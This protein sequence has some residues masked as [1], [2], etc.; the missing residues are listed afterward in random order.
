MKVHFQL[1]CKRVLSLLLMSVL[2]FSLSACTIEWLGEDGEVIIDSSDLMIGIAMPTKAI[3]RWE[4]DGAAINEGLLAAGYKTKL[5]YA[6][7]DPTLQ[8]SQIENMITA[9]CDVMIVV[10]VDSASLSTVLEKAKSKNI[11]ILSYDRLITDTSAVDFYVTFDNYKVGTSMGQFIIDR[12]DL[13]N[14]SGQYNMEIF[15]GP[16]ADN[17]AAF[18]YQ[19]AIDVLQPYINSGVI[20]IPSGQITKEQAAIEGWDLGTAQSRMENLLNAFY[21]DKHLDIALCSNDALARG[22]MNGLLSHGYTV[23][24]PDFPIVTG[25]DCEIA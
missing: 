17:N 8:V 11:R 4:R 16:P 23:G 10:P 15:A 1:V 14:A 2:L 18:F 3:E 19:G 22:A 5:D 25:Q 7:D 21:S 13:S 12:L 9:G 6:N 20:Q 24:A